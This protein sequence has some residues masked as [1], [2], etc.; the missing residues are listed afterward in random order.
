MKK[1]NNL[2][3]TR[4]VLL[5]V[6]A[7]VAISA[8]YQMTISSG[9]LLGPK[10]DGISYEKARSYIT[11]LGPQGLDWYCGKANS[12]IDKNGN[13][14]GQRELEELKRILGNEM[15]LRNDLCE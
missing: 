8:V 9:I 3:L 6:L 2:F 15:R 7:V 1:Q 11:D 13:E 12:F 4:L 14:Y 10:F 5:G